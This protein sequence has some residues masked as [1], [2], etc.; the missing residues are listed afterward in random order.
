MAPFISELYI[1]WIAGELWD[2]LS[3]SIYCAGLPI[4]HSNRYDVTLE[5]TPEPLYN[6]FDRNRSVLIQYIQLRRQ[7]LKAGAENFHSLATNRAFQ[8]W[9]AF[10]IKSDDTCVRIALPPFKFMLAL[11]S[12]HSDSWEH[13]AAMLQSFSRTGNVFMVIMLDILQSQLSQK[14]AEGFC[15]HLKTS[16]ASF[17]AWQT[18]AC[19]KCHQCG[20]SRSQ[21]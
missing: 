21:R 2:G 19:R 16:S 5:D 8:F 6:F 1:Y 3:Y 11:A 18:V 10:N 4:Y 12:Y 20:S 13:S 17:H 15:K 9:K 14:N 7:S